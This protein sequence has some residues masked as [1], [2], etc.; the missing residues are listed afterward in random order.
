MLSNSSPVGEITRHVSRRFGRRP[1]QRHV[2]AVAAAIGQ[3]FGARR[4]GRKR[5][6]VA[7]KAPLSQRPKVSNGSVCPSEMLVI[8]VED[9]CTPISHLLFQVGFS[10][11]PEN[12]ETTLV[13][14]C[15]DVTA[16]P[17]FGTLL[18]IFSSGKVP[19]FPRRVRLLFAS[20]RRNPARRVNLVISMTN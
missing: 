17:C 8:F 16:V 9:I 1:L 4:R 6:I 14:A 18:T 5:D 11:I 12:D 13:F 3:T 15:E 19:F 20:L 7:P 2:A 10:G